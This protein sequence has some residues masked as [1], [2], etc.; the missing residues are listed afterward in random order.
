MNILKEGQIIKGEYKILEK[1]G[2]GA[3]AKVYLAYDMINEIKV[4]LKV[5]K[6][7]NITE[8]KIRSFQREARA[9]SM[10][11]HENIIKIYKIDETDEFHYIVQEYV[12]GITLKEY[13][14]KSSKIGTSEAKNII[15]QIL[16]GLDHAHENKIVHKDIKGQN[17]L[18]NTENKIKITDFG[19]ADI[20]EDEMT[21]TQSL[22]GTPQYVAPEVLNK[23]ESTIQT[24]IYSTGILLYELLIGTA[25]F[26]GEKPTIIIMKQLNQPLPSVKKQREEIPQSMENVLIKATAKKLENRYKSA[27]EMIMDLDTCLDISRAN[28]EPLIIDGDFEYQELTTTNLGDI[29]KIDEN[30]KKNKKRAI[31]LTVSIITLLI[32]ALINFFIFFNKEQLTMTDLEGK[33]QEEA[34]T[35]LENQGLSINNITIEKLSDENI[36]EG[37]VIS[38]TPS[39]GEK[40]NKDTK[41]VLN[42]SSGKEPILLKNYVGKN[43]NDVQKELEELGF[44]VNV[45]SEL[46]EESEGTIL[47][48]N[49]KSGEKYGVGSKVEFVVAKEDTK[50]SLANFLG[51]KE[52]DVDKWLEEN[53]LNASKEYACSDDYD[54]GKIFSQSPGY[55]TEL[56]QTDI[57]KIKISNGTCP[58][59]ATDNTGTNNG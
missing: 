27:E 50:V 26:K 12:E 53:N 39:K 41:V 45:Y 38:S 16:R 21:K 36:E 42:I 52:E 10:L 33:G 58:K 14:E 3:T 24:D 13:I 59:T 2:E 19:I 6:D 1:I 35:V 20:L 5:L 11:N 51:M 56:K 49:P 37:K 46:S 4:A 48:Q 18:I 54:N 7:D 40:I 30:Q 43:I 44:I 8:R 57:V 31:I 29:K 25:P 9:I 15:L 22:M 28:E 32:V 34:I 17:I 55:G 23:G 47:E